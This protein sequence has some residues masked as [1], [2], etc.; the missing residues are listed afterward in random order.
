[1][2]NKFLLILIITLLINLTCYSQQSNELRTY[3]GFTDSKLL[4]KVSLDG[5]ASYENEKNYEFG[6]KYLRKLSP[7]F[8]IEIGVNYLSTKVKITPAFTGITLNLK[9][10]DLKLIYK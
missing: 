10:E 3:F 8:S 1:M 7:K 5:G 6:V 4:R 2:K 9:Q